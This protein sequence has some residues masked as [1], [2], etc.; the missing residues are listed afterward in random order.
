MS[1]I[2]LQLLLINVYTPV[3]GKILVYYGPFS[4]KLCNKLTDQWNQDD[5]LYCGK[6]YITTLS[7]KV[8]F[9]ATSKV[10]L[11]LTGLAR[12]DLSFLKKL[13]DKLINK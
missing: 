11:I 2:T 10:V 5:S 1:Q 6:G 8:I 7:G 9:T 13:S 4:L 12:N 3:C